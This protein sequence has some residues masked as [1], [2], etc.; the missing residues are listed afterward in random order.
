MSIYVLEELR[1]TR[2]ILWIGIH[3]VSWTSLNVLISILRRGDG[4]PCFIKIVKFLLMQLNLMSLRFKIGASVNF[5]APLNQAKL[6]PV[7]L[8]GT[9]NT[10][11][12]TPPQGNMYSGSVL[13]TPP[14]ILITRTILQKY[15]NLTAGALHYRTPQHSSTWN[16]SFRFCFTVYRECASN[17]RSIFSL[18]I[19]TSVDGIIR[20]VFID[21]WFW[22]GVFALFLRSK[23]GEHFSTLHRTLRNFFENWKYSKF[24]FISK[25]I[26]ST[27]YLS[28][29]PRT[30]HCFQTLSPRTRIVLVTCWG[31]KKYSGGLSNDGNENYQTH[32]NSVKATIRNI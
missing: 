25:S 27:V 4:I 10:T 8:M 18:L 2:L 32:I 1:P 11:R 12:K 21:R 23:G 24:A 9:C 19:K 13:S 15:G 30:V 5:Q 20:G 14:L 31:L 29:L 26:T 17:V 6:D 22:I 3:L 7:T 28:V 16:D